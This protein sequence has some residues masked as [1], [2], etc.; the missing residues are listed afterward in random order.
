LKEKE[1]FRKFKSKLIIIITGDFYL[2]DSQI[3][4]EDKD[5]LYSQMVKAIKKVSDLSKKFNID[6]IK[7]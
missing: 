4:K 5:R 2:R 6:I 7:N 3:P 1:T